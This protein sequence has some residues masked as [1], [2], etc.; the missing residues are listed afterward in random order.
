[1]SE[2]R[3]PQE[4]IRALPKK[5]R[6]RLK[7]HACWGCEIG[8]DKGWCSAT[9]APMCTRAELLDRASRCLAAS[10][11][12]EVREAAGELADEASR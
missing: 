2:I 8:L 3:S 7:R 6:D 9:G 4:I 11:V 5:A 10:R 1:M 12:A